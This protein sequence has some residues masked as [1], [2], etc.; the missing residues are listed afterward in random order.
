MNITRENILWT[1]YSKN[2]VVLRV[3]KLGLQSLDLLN[4]LSEPFLNYCNQN[5]T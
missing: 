1:C 3:D 5:G 4:H 2:N